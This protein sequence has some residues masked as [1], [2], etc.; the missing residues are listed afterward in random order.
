MMSVVFPVPV[1][2]M[3]SKC[4]ASAASGI[5]IMALASSV[6]KPIPS[7]CTASLNSLGVSMTGP[8]R[9]LPYFIC[10]RRLMSFAMENGSVEGIQADQRL[11]RLLPD[12]VVD[13]VRAVG[14][15]VRQQPRALFAEVIEE[16]REGFLVPALGGPDDP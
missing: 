14:R 13:P 6:L 16:L 5:R 2:P 11:R 7:P 8:L 4:C 1:S 3:I 15:H 9:T 10:L 12:D